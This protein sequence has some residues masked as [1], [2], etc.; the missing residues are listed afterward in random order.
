MYHAFTFFFDEMIE[1]N[2]TVSRFDVSRGL[3]D[4]LY[5]RLINP[6][7]YQNF[8]YS[9]EKLKKLITFLY[10]FE[11]ITKK[12]YF[13]AVYGTDDENV[14]I[15]VGGIGVDITETKRL[16]EQLIQTQRIAVFMDY[17]LLVIYRQEHRLTQR[18]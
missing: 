18:L 12:A 10:D 13:L 5:K 8:Y 15:G 6:K 14:I 16:N 3:F 11:L 2:T 1:S 9:N 17:I 7:T 4:I